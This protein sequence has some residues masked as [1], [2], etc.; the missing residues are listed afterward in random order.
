MRS[1]IA[2]AQQKRS[3]LNVLNLNV[4][5]WSVAILCFTLIQDLLNWPILQFARVVSPIKYRDT[6][7][8]LADADCFRNIGSGIYG[9]QSETGCPGYIY[10]T[11]LLRVLNFLQIGQE[12]TRAFTYL[13]R[14]LFALSIALILKNLKINF[15]KQLLLSGLLL[16]SPGVQ[17][18]LYNSNFDLLIFAMITFAHYGIQNK[19]VTFG[20]LLIFLTGIF[21]FYTIPLLLLF[22]FLLPNFKYKLFSTALFVIASASAVSDLRLMQEPIPSSGYAQFG[23]TIFTKYIEEFGYSLSVAQNY[24][25]SSGL[26]LVTAVIVTLF[27]RRYLQSHI[28]EQLI[29]NP[30]YLVVSTVFISCFFTGIS[31][32]PRLVYLTLAG[33]MIVQS[34]DPGPSRK[35]MWLGVLA[36]SLL[37]CG[38]ELGFIPEEHT[39]FHALRSIQLI[40]DLAIEFL[41]VVLFLSLLNWFFRLTRSLISRN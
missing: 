25:L 37:S 3:F 5:I 23:L 35:F 6:F 11:P 15:K 40:N 24:I 1:T 9:L 29:S 21:K 7:W 17:L 13:M 16:F 2:A 10:G 20:L 26:F 28:C 30:L 14:A 18:M 33:F 4:A 41:S 31:F 22:V 32:D 39:G 27:K 36:A 19:K 38:I 8:V 34:M 12:D